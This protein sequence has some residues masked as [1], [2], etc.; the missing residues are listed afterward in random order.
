MSIA[1]YD[2]NMLFDIS[3]NGVDKATSNVLIIYN[4]VVMNML[5]SRRNLRFS[6][7]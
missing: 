1:P 5:L 7:Q 4:P 2:F 3:V 6:S